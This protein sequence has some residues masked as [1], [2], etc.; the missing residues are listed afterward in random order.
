LCSIY[1]EPSLEAAMDGV[2]RGDSGFAQTLMGRR[3]L[4][5]RAFVAAAAASCAACLL[6]RA[7]AT[8]AAAPQEAPTLSDA[9]GV[10]AKEQSAAEQYAVILATVGRKDVASYVRGIQLY[11]DAKAEFDGLIAELKIDLIDGRDPAKSQKFA[12]AMQAAAKSRIAFTD[13]VSDDVVGK[14]T[15]AKP[16]LMDVVKVVPELVTALTDAGLKIW[17]AYTSASKERRDAILSE[18]DHLRWRAFADLAPKEN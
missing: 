15:G 17:N 5:R 7:Q 12:A 8:Q 6:P 1:F 18:I 9:V 14:Q 4:S 11:A 13:F 3:R 2:R 16:G 10:L